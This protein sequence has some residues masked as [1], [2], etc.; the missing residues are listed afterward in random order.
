MK[1]YPFVERRVIATLA[2]LG[3]AMIWT[4]AF[5]AI[6]R[7]MN[8]ETSPQAWPIT[9]AALIVTLP[10]ML[11]GSKRKAVLL[12]FGVGIVAFGLFRWLLPGSG[13]GPLAL[14]AVGPVMT[15]GGHWLTRKLPVDLDGVR[16]RRILTSALWCLLALLALVQTARLTTY[17][18]DPTSDWY[19]STRNP[20]WAKHE[21]MTAYFY[22]AELA[23][24]GERNLYD[25]IHYP[26]L[27]P[28]AQPT[29]QMQGM[30]V[31]DPFQYPPQFLLL[32]KFASMLTQNFSTIRVVWFA[33]QASFFVTIAMALAQWIGGRSGRLAAWL[34]PLA[35]SA[36]PTL[37]A[38]QYGQFHLAAIV[39]SMT[40]FLAFEKGRSVTG[41]ALLAAAVSAKIFPGFLLVVLAVQKR[42]KALGWTLGFM[43]AIAFL[44]L[45]V[46]GPDPFVAF[47]QY[48]VPRLADGSAFA[49]GEA[50][51]E[52]RELIIADN[53]AVF[54]LVVKFQEMGL[55]FLHEGVAKT[56]GTF[57]SLLL[58][59]F[60]A[61]FAL[62]ERQLARVDRAAG[63]LAVLGLASLAGGAAF[64]DYVPLTAVWLLTLVSGHMR[65][66]MLWVLALGICWVFQY[67][68]LGTVPLGDFAPPGLMIPLSAFGAISLL[69][70]FGGA[71]GG[72]LAQGE[73][74]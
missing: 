15:A 72:F 31:E 57:F 69:W 44:G 68:I 53:Q 55:P 19:L 5:A 65:K 7:D 41:G 12:S 42:W 71:L 50:W 36:F 66:G 4:H 11:V 70:L 27:N 8:P 46:L 10:G 14:L 61:V 33:I 60:T 74:S 38:L 52:I 20:F 22:G 16:N 23:D 24:R 73:A 51:P 34:I 28:E 26:G 9:I 18:A 25:T 67:T 45:V 64:G 30:V 37:Q 47:L 6:L 39:L 3:G 1:V 58:L 13:V 63:W 32:P 17:M 62:K 21:C 40:A 48:Q 56:A 29:T 35:F 2:A 49:F 54:G 43:T 59:V